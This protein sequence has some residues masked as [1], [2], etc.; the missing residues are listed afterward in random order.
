MPKETFINLSLEKQ[1][2]VMRAAIHEFLTHGYESGNIGEIAKNAGVAK[3]S[4]YQYF[5][6][7]KE[8]FL[9]SVHWTMELFMKIDSNSMLFQTKDINFFDVLNMTLDQGWIQLKEE[10]EAAL[11]MQEVMLGTFN[12]VAA[13]SRKAMLKTS[14]DFLLKLIKDGQK[15]GY[16][17]TD[18]DDEM[19]LMFLLG[20]SMR[21][22]EKF[23][24]QARLS[25]TAFSDEYLEVYRKKLKSIFELILNGMGVK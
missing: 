21:F 1:E 19:L 6:N 18:I 23:L 8:L 24:N 17:R 15:N 3:G 4:M 20:A 16:F 11:F 13:E 7:K 25:E 12:P 22:K 5:E 9:Y 14:E 2:K 10:K